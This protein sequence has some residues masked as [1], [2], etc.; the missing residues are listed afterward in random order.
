MPVSDIATIVMDTP[1]PEP[2][3]YAAASWPTVAAVAASAL[4]AG[5]AGMVWAAKK[6]LLLA[7]VSCWFCQAPAKVRYSHRNSWTCPGCGQYNGFG[8]DGDYNRDDP[9]RWRQWPRGEAPRFA[10]SGSVSKDAN[11]GLCHTCNLNQT[12]KVEQLARFKPTKE[13]N[14]DKEV[15]AFQDQL[16]RTYRL[17]RKCKY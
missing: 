3:E 12:L 5:G 11:N 1:L 13:A 16:E 2:E 10:A 15:E 8:A 6:G 17:C 14:F 7:R 4:V 9:D